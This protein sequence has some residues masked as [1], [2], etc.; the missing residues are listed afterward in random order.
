[1]GIGRSARQEHVRGC[2]FYIPLHAARRSKCANCRG[3][4]F[5]QANACPKKAARGDTKGWRP[6]SPKWRQRGETSQPEQPPTTAG[7]EPEGEVEEE[8]QH[9]PAPG[10]EMEE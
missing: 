2:V 8:T 4:H 6:P 5:A 9:E 1:M 7:G 3:P 10:E